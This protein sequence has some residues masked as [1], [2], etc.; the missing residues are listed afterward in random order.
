[1]TSVNLCHSQEYITFSLEFELHRGNP[2]AL[3]RLVREGGVESPDAS[4]V[5]TS[6]G[7]S[8]MCVGKHHAGALREG[9]LSTDSSMITQTTCSRINLGHH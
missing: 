6:T 7:T 1:M 8:G 3:R 5:F 9:T 2:L 4:L